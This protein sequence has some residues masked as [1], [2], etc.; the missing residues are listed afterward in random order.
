[1]NLSTLD[2][3][4]QQNVPASQTLSSPGFA[5][6]TGSSDDAF[7]LIARGPGLC[8]KE[9]QE[10][11]QLQLSQKGLKVAPVLPQPSPHPNLNAEGLSDFSPHY[12]SAQMRARMQ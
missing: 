6:G 11:L 7:Q 10:S 1:M 5:A 9:R 12:T 4:D 2:Q 3:Q 8:A